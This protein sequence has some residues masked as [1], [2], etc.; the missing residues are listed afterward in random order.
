MN[1]LK[2]KLI[3]LGAFFLLSVA[4]ISASQAQFY[5]PPV[6]PFYG[7]AYGFVPTFAPA[8]FASLAPSYGTVYEAPYAYRGAHALLTQ[9]ALLGLLPSTTTTTSTLLPSYTT[10]TT[11]TTLSTTTST[12]GYTTA[13]L[14]G[15][16]SSSTTTALLLS[17]ATTPTTTSTIG[18]TTALLLGGTSTTTL[19]A[20]GI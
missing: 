4:T 17:S 11:P 1:S 15:G 6:N 12:I 14:L 13:L 8:P 5:Y 10:Y 2:K 16:S 18:T 20:L 19:L 7:Y 9:L 3:V